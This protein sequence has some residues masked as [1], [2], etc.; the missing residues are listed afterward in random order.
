MPLINPSINIDSILL[1]RVRAWRQR[2]GGRRKLK[3]RSLLA[4]PAKES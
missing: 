1:L 3:R 4:R 2:T